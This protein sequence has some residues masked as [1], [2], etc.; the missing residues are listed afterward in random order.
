MAATGGAQG[1]PDAEVRV[2]VAA[3][4]LLGESP[5][6]H[7][8]EQVLYHCDIPGR[9]L[10]RHDPRTGDSRHWQFDCEVASVAPAL[11][12]RL[13]LAM[14]DGLWH[15]DP[16]SGQRS[17]AA[18]PPY[19]PSVERFNDGKCDPQGRFWVGTVYEPRDAPKA[20]LYCFD[21]GRLER[22]LGGLTVANG[23]GWSPD[24]RTM[25]WAD[26]RAHALYAADFDG[27]TG[28]I[29]TPRLFGEFARQ[30]DGLRADGTRTKYG[31][32]PDGAAVDVDGGYWVAM[33]EGARLLRFKPDGSLCREIALPVAC[34]TMPCFGGADLK[35]LYVT[36]AREGRPAAELVEQPYAG[37]VLAVE[38]EVA[39]LPANFA[40]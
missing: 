33:F 12:G 2:A 29:G 37:C 14:R 13:L 9:R 25:H 30:A 6:W 34:P 18:A 15:F 31:G 17:L 19:D 7:P 10:H 4:S 26:T 39:G 24:G 32:R 40:R 3:A 11:G 16:A 5:L 22:R 23:L 20:A 36:T 38:V 27:A 21:R 35:T 28:R 8:G 1:A